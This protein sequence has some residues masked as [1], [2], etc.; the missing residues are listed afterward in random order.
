MTIPNWQLRALGAQ[1]MN[2]G[3]VLFTGTLKIITVVSFDNTDRVVK[4]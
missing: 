2:I 1:G 4:L 3:V